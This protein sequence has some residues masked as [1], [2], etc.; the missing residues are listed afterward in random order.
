MEEDLFTLENVLDLIQ[1]V[2][3]IKSVR[4]ITEINVLPRTNSC[5]K[6]RER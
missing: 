4:S 3:V 1:I 5:E 6:K 2:Q